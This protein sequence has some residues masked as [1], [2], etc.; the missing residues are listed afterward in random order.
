MKTLW[1]ALM[2]D[3]RGKLGGHVAQRG[4]YGNILRTK[5][6]PINKN[7]V[8]QQHRRITTAELTQG[9]A[10]L[11]EDQRKGWNDFATDNPVTDIFGNKIDLSGINMYCKINMNFE[12]VGL[13]RAAS[14]PR[15]DARRLKR[16]YKAQL[17]GQGG[18]ITIDSNVPIATGILVGVYAS[19]AVSPGITL[20]NNRFKHITILSDTDTFPV[21]ITTA[22]EHYFGPA[23]ATGD[24]IFTRLVQIS[25][26]SGLASPPIISSAILTEAVPPP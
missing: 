4:P 3:G 22:Y 5:T 7:T 14:H 20:L 1:G 2:V 10:G 9:W 21:D 24:K 15:R 11:T 18:I 19:P 17:K 16:F 26:I 25:D 23:V 8:L 13:P 6:T 12:S